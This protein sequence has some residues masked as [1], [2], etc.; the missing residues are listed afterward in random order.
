MESTISENRTQSV[1]RE[2]KKNTKVKLL[3]I[4]GLQEIAQIVQDILLAVITMDHALVVCHNVDKLICF[5][6]SHRAFCTM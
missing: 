5:T 6:L 3:Q 4:I 1:G 2:C